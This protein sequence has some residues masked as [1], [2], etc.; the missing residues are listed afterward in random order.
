MWNEEESIGYISPNVMYDCIVSHNEKIEEEH[1]E[2][3]CLWDVAFLYIL[4]VEW[5]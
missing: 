2:S 5:C 1:I 3:L 4:F